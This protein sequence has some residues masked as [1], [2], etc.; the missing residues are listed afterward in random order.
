MFAKKFFKYVQ[1]AKIH[2]DRE[3]ALDEREQYLN[4]Y[5]NMLNKLEEQIN[6]RE[7]QNEQYAQ[8]NEK[9]KQ[10]QGRAQQ[11]LLN[12]LSSLRHGLYFRIWETNYQFCSKIPFFFPPI[13]KTN[14]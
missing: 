14:P 12:K 10:N 13:L 7:I 3:K 4:E 11:G 6:E 5:E 8:E 1:L 2:N 9:H